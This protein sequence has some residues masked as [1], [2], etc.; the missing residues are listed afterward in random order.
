[1]LAAGTTSAAAY[2]YQFKISS[3]SVGYNSENPGWK[4]PGYGYCLVAVNKIDNTIWNTG[5]KRK[6][7][8]LVV[9]TD[10]LQI[11][12]NAGIWGGTSASLRFY[13]PDHAGDVYLRANSTETGVGY[14]AIGTWN[15]NCNE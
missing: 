4:I 8:F 9:A 13:T 1:M 12:T 7:N 5:T 2:T 11:S 10:M 14:T 3:K 6:T 15:P